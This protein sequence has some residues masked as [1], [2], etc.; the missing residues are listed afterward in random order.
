MS[1]TYTRS[2]YQ[3]DQ[4]VRWC[5]GCGD[6]T[7]LASVQ[8]FLAGLAVTL[9][10]PKIMVFYLALLPTIVDLGGVA[11]GEWLQLS[12]TALIVLACVDIAWVVLAARARILLRTPAA[13]RFTNMGSW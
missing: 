9:G 13:V 10:N 6:Y 4:E 2:D 1:T 11:A 8:M 7:I 5:P 12:I 3:T